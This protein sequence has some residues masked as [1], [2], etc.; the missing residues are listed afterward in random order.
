MEY[1]CNICPRKCNKIRTLTNGNG[2]CKM[3]YEAKIS[4]YGLHMWEEPCVSG[5]NGSGTIFFTG[6]NLQ[7][8]YCQNYKITRGNL[9]GIGETKTKEDIVN[10]CYDLIEKGAHNI[11]FVTPTHYSYIVK[12]IL[13]EHKSKFNVPIVYNTS[14]YE[15]VKQIRELDGLVDV[16]LPD[17]KYANKDISAKYSKAPN[18]FEVVTQNIL[19][20][21]NQVGECEFDNEVMITKGVIVRHLILPNNIKN[22]ISVLQWCKDNL[23]TDVMISVMAQYIPVGDI[24]EYPELQRKINK[25]EYNR[26]LNYI[27]ENNIENGYI[28]ELSSASIKYIPD[29]K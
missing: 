28:Q 27:I 19:E 12:E 8:V 18:Y 24:Q 23:P 7:C 21:Y 3:P 29:F 9:E 17:F 6:C 5:K 2:I 1:V 15:D 26:V 25:I 11:N 10:M 16:Y 14:G 22:T 13:K 20:M 4:R